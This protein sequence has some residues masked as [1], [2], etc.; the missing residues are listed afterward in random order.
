MSR[1]V[2][3]VT[4]DDAFQPQIIKNYH[5]NLKLEWNVGVYYKSLYNFQLAKRLFNLL[6]TELFKVFKKLDIGMKR[7]IKKFEKDNMMIIKKI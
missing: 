5:D 2:S 4:Y 3:E 7:V 6:K 1:N